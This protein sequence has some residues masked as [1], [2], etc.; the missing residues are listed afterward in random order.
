MTTTKLQ[1]L[2]FFDPFCGWCYAAAPAL[3][4]L[5]ETWPTSLKMMPSGLFSGPNAR[6]M[7]QGLADYAWQNDQRIE[8]L[9]GERFT[10][11]YRDNLL[12]GENLHFD[13]GPATRAMTALAA[14]DIA[15]EPAFLH[16]A[17]LARY[18]DGLDTT[19][20]ATLA[21][22]AADLAASAG[23]AL[24]PDAF[25]KLIETSETLRDT[26]AQR[27]ATSFAAMQRLPSSGVPQ[28]AVVADGRAG[29]LN[30]ETL[31]SG[32]DVAIATVRKFLDGA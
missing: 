21:A 3:A 31:Y 11:F 29:V 23:I 12:R 1:L 24:D 15:L 10:T 16:A 28:L 14:I 20:P 9:T 7:T 2:Y 6:P 26:T 8:Q 17:Q 27:I 32:P 18:V 30:G 4:G 25:A 22:I 5:A 13:S 19:K